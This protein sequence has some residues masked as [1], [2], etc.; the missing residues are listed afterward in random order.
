MVTRLGRAAVRNVHSHLDG[1][2]VLGIQL[3]DLRIDRGI[4]GVGLAIAVRSH[5][6]LDVGL[7]LAIVLDL[8]VPDH[9]VRLGR[10]AVVT[11]QLLISRQ[12][13]RVETTTVTGGGGHGDIVVGRGSDAARG[14][15][16]HCRLTVAIG[17]VVHRYG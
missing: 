10:V 13:D 12:F 14:L 15:G 3:Q 8:D 16:V 11:L 6:Q 9:T 5:L 17:L 1:L 2:L 4:E 7:L